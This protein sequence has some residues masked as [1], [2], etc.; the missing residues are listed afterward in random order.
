M[1]PDSIGKA[2]HMEEQ[3]VRN[4]IE[5]LIGGIGKF[6]CDAC[7]GKAVTELE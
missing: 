2:G 3:L 4:E 1:H 7:I 6:I 5:K